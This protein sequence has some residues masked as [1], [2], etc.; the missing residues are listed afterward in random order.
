MGLFFKRGDLDDRLKKLERDFTALQLEWEEVYDKLL[1]NM[2]RI[3]QAAAYAQERE[4]AEQAGGA[5]AFT[6]PDNPTQT[7]FLTPRQRAIQQQIIG[8]RHQVGGNAR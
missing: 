5:A 3:R 1:K 7:G 6:A 4:E 8:R 2:R